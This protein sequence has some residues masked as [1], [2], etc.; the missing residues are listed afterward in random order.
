M[1]ALE[2]GKRKIEQR[3][4]QV[5]GNINIASIPTAIGILLPKLIKH[6]QQESSNS[7]HFIYHDNPS[8]QIC[9]GINKGWY[10][11]GICSF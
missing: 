11:I 4:S 5:Q 1:D 8:Y 10:D 3:I 9:E 2:Y 6:Y 7:P